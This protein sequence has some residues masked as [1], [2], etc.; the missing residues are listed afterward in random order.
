MNMGATS[1]LPQAAKET[2]QEFTTTNV[3][4]EPQ[5]PAGTRQSP[6]GTKSPSETIAQVAMEDTTQE[7]QPISMEPVSP[8]GTKAAEDLSSIPE[9]SVDTNKESPKMVGQPEEVVNAEVNSEAAAASEGP[10][11]VDD[12]STEEL[13]ANEPV[14]QEAE[15]EERVPKKKKG[16]PHTSQDEERIRISAILEE[17]GYDFDEVLLWSVPHMAAELD[18]VQQQEQAA[19]AASKARVVLTKK[20]KET[21]YRDK[22]KAFLLQY[23]FH[24]RQL[25]PMK[26]ST[27]DMHVRDIKA[28]VA[29]GE[30]PSIEQIQAQRA[31]LNLGLGLEGGATIEIPLSGAGIREGEEVMCGE[32][33]KSMFPNMFP[34]NPKAEPASPPSSPSMD[35]MPI[36]SVIKI[37]KG[38]KTTRKQ[39]ST[40]PDHDHERQTQADERRTEPSTTEDAG[41]Q[42]TATTGAAVGSNV[43]DDQARDQRSQATA[44]ER[45]RFRRRKSIARRKKRTTVIS[46]DSEP[47]SPSSGPKAT[48]DNPLLKD[49]SRNLYDLMHHYT[50]IPIINWSFNALHKEFTLY[51]MN[52]GIKVLDLTKL[53]VLAQPFIFDLERLPLENLDNGSDGRVGVTIR[54]FTLTLLTEDGDIIGPTRPMKAQ[55][56][57]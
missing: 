19:A 9:H 25:G 36:S 56:G 40:D 26:N 22:L 35:N 34:L 49:Q 42:P 3:S 16:R 44:Q 57:Q 50:Y 20:Q 29:R 18:K 4:L 51:Q 32:A 7:E 47:D 43:E 39:Q 2:E 55:Q 46:S 5:S 6:S 41:P 13:L 15:L 38:K 30:L 52:G 48:P 10:V 33:T 45:P 8:S 23:G 24:A 31:S 14:E 28:K 37:N 17:K 1:Y 53:M 11:I 54:L 21:A 27:M 12:S